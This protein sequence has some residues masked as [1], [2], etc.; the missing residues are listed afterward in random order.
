MYLELLVISFF[1]LY[2]VN[3]L[4]LSFGNLKLYSGIADPPTRPLL[5]FNKINILLNISRN[6]LR[7][8]LPDQCTRP[9][10]SVQNVLTLKNQS[11]V[12]AT[13]KKVLCRNL[14]MA[15][16]YLH[17]HTQGPPRGSAQHIYEQFQ[18]QHHSLSI[19]SNFI[20]GYACSFRN[21]FMLQHVKFNL[22]YFSETI[23][24]VFLH[25]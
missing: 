20:N 19:L 18:L 7:T 15:N 17:L 13:L 22:T 9:L 21:S 12:S 24:D 25:Y 10:S 14:R 2:E 23:K 4:F 5:K 3:F 16:R 1:L 8:K 6:D 11:F